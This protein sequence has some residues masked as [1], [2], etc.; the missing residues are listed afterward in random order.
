VTPNKARFREPI[1]KF[2]GTVMLDLQT[3]GNFGNPRPPAWWKPFQ[4]Q[5]QLVLPGLES[6]P[7]SVLFTEV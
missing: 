2:H 5:H 6:N 3:F 1:H 7:A 4:R